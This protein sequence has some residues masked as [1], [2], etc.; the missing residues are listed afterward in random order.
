MIHGFQLKIAN[1]QHLLLNFISEILIKIRNIYLTLIFLTRFVF[2]KYGKISTE[3]NKIEKSMILK[4]KNSRI[5]LREF[6]NQPMKILTWLC[7]LYAAHQID[8]N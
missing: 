3:I 1:A 6:S 4:L 7:S 5:T 2:Y 8:I